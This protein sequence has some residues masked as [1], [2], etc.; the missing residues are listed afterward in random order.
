MRKPKADVQVTGR[1]VAYIQK[2]S[3]SGKAGKAAPYVITTVRA[4]RTPTPVPV[5]KVR[6]RKRK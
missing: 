6:R 5:K 1:A 2:V 3:K 4:S